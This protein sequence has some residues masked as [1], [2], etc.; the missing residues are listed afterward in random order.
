M[1]SVCDQEVAAYFT[2]ASSANRLS[3]SC[4]LWYRNSWNLLDLILATGLVDGYCAVV[5]KLWIT[6]PSVLSLHRVI[7]I[8]VDLSWCT[9]LASDLQQMLM[10]SKLSPCYRRLTLISS[11]LGYKCWFHGEKKYLNVEGDNVEV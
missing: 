5:G 9:S 6:L 7:S 2:S 10:H 8:S 4:F 11:V 1:I 3:A